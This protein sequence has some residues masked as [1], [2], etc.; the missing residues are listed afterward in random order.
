M[1]PKLQ[2]ALDTL[3]MNEAIRL[4]HL[5]QDY[6]EILEIGTTL[7]LAEG[8]ESVRQFRRTF[9]EATLLADTKIVDAG[10]VLAG[11]ACEAGADLVTVISAA[12]TKTIQSAAKAAHECGAEVLL[13]HLGETWSS[14]AL[15]GLG[16]LGVDRIGLH[17]PIDLQGDH[18]IQP[19]IVH[20]IVEIVPLPVSLAGGITAEKVTQ[21]CDTGVEV[22]VVGGYLL[23]AD[24]PVAH[25]KLLRSALAGSSYE[26]NH[27]KNK[28]TY[29]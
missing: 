3:S 14:D 24:D 13:D 16:E 8:L 7:L 5:L 12:S 18:I 20:S 4:A 22:F 19:D 2:L 1:T 28:E 21:L 29:F 11:A 10:A 15:P 23:K 26:L 6:W 27:I 9:P 25:A 17:L